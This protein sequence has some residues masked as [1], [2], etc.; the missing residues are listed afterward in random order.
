M[1]DYSKKRSEAAKWMFERRDRVDFWNW[2]VLTDH[3][4]DPESLGFDDIVAWSIFRDLVKD[5]LLIPIFDSKLGEGYTFHPGKEAQ[6]K[7][8]TSPFQYSVKRFVWN[9]FWWLLATIL[10]AVIGIGVGD[11]WDIFFGK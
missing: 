8:A 3:N 5:D 4:P 10:S 2:N 11:W 9:N 6:W 7:E 1:K